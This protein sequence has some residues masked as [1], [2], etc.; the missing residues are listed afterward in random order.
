M[1]V[2]VNATMVILSL[3]VSLDLVPVSLL[4]LPSVTS[5]SN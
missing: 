5:G 3:F 4:G 1:A 2:K